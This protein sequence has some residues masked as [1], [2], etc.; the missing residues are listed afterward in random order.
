MSDVNG[1]NLV[2]TSFEDL[3]RD[4]RPERPQFPM[5]DERTSSRDLHDLVAER[6]FM[7]TSG[8]VAGGAAAV[9]V[10]LIL[11][12]Y[13]RPLLDT[14]EAFHTAGQVAADKAAQQIH[15]VQSTVGGLAE[16]AATVKAN[17]EKAINTARGGFDCLTGKRA[18]PNGASPFR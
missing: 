4:T 2:P 12:A 5:A 17:D 6:G 1:R 9:G 13:G 10:L 11:F 14:F 3:R 8:L 16:K 15:G 18:C 7:R